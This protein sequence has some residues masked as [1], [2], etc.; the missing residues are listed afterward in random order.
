LLFG[1]DQGVLSGLLLSDNFVDQFQL[2]DPN[3]TQRAQKVA[4][5]VSLYEIGCMF[6][7]IS[8]LIWGEWMGR[9]VSMMIGSTILICGAAI[10]A[11]SFT[12]A[13]MIVG[14]IVAG[15]GN[16]MNTASIPVYNSEVSRPKHRGRDL[17]FGQAMLIAGIAISYWI[18]YGFSFLDSAVNWRFPIAFQ[19][20]FA[21]LLILMLID[22]PESPRYLLAHGRIDEARV[23][24]AHLTGEGFKPTDSV[25]L[26]Q[27]KEIEDSIALERGLGDSF[28]W[29]ELWEGGELQNGR[30]MALCFGIQLMQQMGGINLITYYLTIVFRSIGLS[31]NL[32]RLLSGFNGL[33]YCAAA[34]IPVFFI[35]KLGRRKSMMCCAVGCCASMLVL[36]TLLATGARGNKVRGSV[37]ASMMFV[38]NTFFA[39]GWLCIPWLYPAEICTLRLRSKGAA[40]ATVS[41]WLFNFVIVQITPLAIQ[42]LDW[43]T[44]IMFAVFNAA[45]IPAVY[46]FYPETA[47][48][49]LESID[50][51]FQSPDKNK[52]GT[53]IDVLDRGTGG[54]SPSEEKM[55]T[56]EITK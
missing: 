19:T 1:Y 29:K 51:I 50:T 38:F 11:S 52:I 55:S 13:Q 26:A 8:V 28:Q 16:G 49:P 18:D 22:L 20:T 56:N 3:G 42:N 5:I 54:D 10:Q 30:R 47:L 34:F 25:V 37:A 17:A 40:I 14:R 23:V 33:E 6:G 7:A 32:S 4:T 48:K 31:K 2:E 46:F 36:G 35:E 15:F 53:G 43:R 27:S 12:V 44:Y 21:L 41:N 45:F 24:L 39:V 9:R